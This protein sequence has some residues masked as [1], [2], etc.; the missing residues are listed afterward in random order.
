MTQEGDVGRFQSWRERELR[1]VKKTYLVIGQ[2]VRLAEVV[3]Y[4]LQSNHI[5]QGHQYRTKVN[6]HLPGKGMSSISSAQ[7]PK[8][9][10]VSQ[11]HVRGGSR[12]IRSV[13][14]SAKKFPRDIFWAFCFPGA[15]QIHLLASDV[16][17]A[18][19]NEATVMASRQWEGSTHP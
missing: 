19:K 11:V 4:R 14:S 6:K 1:S 2:C 16:Q 8:S 18:L 5:S 12:E 17:P 7:E 13:L 15:I 3:A 10:L 9:T